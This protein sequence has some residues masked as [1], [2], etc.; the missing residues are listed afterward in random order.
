MAGTPW[1]SHDWHADFHDPGDTAS[2][3]GS[4]A[5]NGSGLSPNELYL[6]QAAANANALLI[7]NPFINGSDT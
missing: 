2:P 7:T 1:A 5:I 4:Y 3:A 6:A